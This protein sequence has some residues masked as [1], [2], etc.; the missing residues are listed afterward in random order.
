MG[1]ILY[2]RKYK[3]H[4]ISI[5][6]ILIMLI[7]A[8]STSKGRV[9][10]SLKIINNSSYNLKLKILGNDFDQDGNRREFEEKFTINI[11]QEKNININGH[12]SPHPFMYIYEI[13]IY[14]ENDELIKGFRSYDDNYESVSTIFIKKNVWVITDGEF[15]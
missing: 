8:L 3:K 10:A 13:F 1:D 12:N 15:E 9:D 6:F 4:I 5:L 2:M 14:N 11:G 7:I